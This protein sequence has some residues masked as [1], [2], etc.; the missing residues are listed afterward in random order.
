MRDHLP[1][2]I[3]IAAIAGFGGLMFYFFSYYQEH[4]TR[5]EELRLQQEKEKLAAN[6]V[7]K[8]Q[9]A[10]SERQSQLR[11]KEQEELRAQQADANAKKQLAQALE[12]ERIRKQMETMKEEQR[13]KQEA[14]DAKR[15]EEYAKDQAEREAKA[16]KDRAEW[17]AQN[18]IKT[19]EEKAKAI[20]QAKI[21]LK[22]D[23]AK[24]HEAER[25]LAK[26]KSDFTAAKNRAEIAARQM[27]DAYN[28]GVSWGKQMGY[29]A[30]Y[31]PGNRRDK[32]YWGW[33]S[34]TIGKGSVLPGG[35]TVTVDTR[36]QIGKA[37][38]KFEFAQK[39]NTKMLA[40][41]KSAEEQMTAS[42]QQ[43]DSAKRGIDAMTAF[44]KENEGGAGDDVATTAPVEAGPPPA[45][46]NTNETE[47]STENGNGDPNIE[48]EINNGL[49][50]IFIMKDKSKV[51]A[52]MVMRAGDTVVIK[53][54]DGEVI[55]L[56]TKDIESELPMQKK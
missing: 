34:P 9:L 10:E 48:A 35:I 12:R 33:Y 21:D 1:M 55:K 5:Q 13:K 6:E 36:E 51:Y 15:R 18:A 4:K 42:Q 43:I 37:K 47:T 39:E 22:N 14:E 3:V 25:S 50:A 49:K 20:A 27:Q 16:A 2:L 30:F 54:K 53:N 11:K 8:A 24:L 38:G 32:Y 46:V 23:T 52:Y 56:A 28:D 7:A 41:Q 44:L 29:S 17:E 45:N 19:K 31:N 40:L 26:A